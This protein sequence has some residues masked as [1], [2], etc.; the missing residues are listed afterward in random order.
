MSAR[1][2]AERSFMDGGPDEVGPDEIGMRLRRA[3]EA[4][5][6]AHYD[7]QGTALGEAGSREAAKAMAAALAETGIAGRIL[8]GLSG[9]GVPSMLETGALLSSD[10]LGAGHDRAEAPLDLLL[11]PAEGASFLVPGHS[12]AMAVIAAASPGGLAELTPALYMEKLVAGAAARGRIDIEAPIE[13]RL[14]QLARA[15]GKP[16][17]GLTIFIVEKPRH[18]G[19]IERIHGCGAGVVLQPAGDVG[20][21]L[22]ALLPERGIDALMGT[23]GLAEGLM[24]ALAA[25]VLGGTFFARLDPQL[26]SERMAIKRAGLDTGRWRELDGIVPAARIHFAATGIAEGALL[27]G[28]RRGNGLDRSETLILGPGP[29]RYFLK[30]ERPQRS[31]RGG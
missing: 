19:L 30:T 4:A 1:G 22:L 11:D 31:G 13:E 14:A 8:S 17:A 21:A 23:G 24:A 28:V 2:E 29:E 9:P 20:G 5:A 16:I 10:A 7:H 12:S 15:L 25:K 18:R 27:S 6:L 3:T 26:P